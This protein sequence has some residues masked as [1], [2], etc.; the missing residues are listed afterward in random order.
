MLCVPLASVA[1]V[2][3]ATPLLRV[4]LPSVLVPSLNVTVPPGVP[5]NCGLMVAV[6]VT[7]SPTVDGFADEVSVVV[8]LALFTTWLTA[9][10][11]LR[12]ND[13]LPL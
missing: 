4:T 11:V 9:V 1:V 2:Y 12:L 5:L 10:E 8:V 7:D 6:K 13:A 3:F